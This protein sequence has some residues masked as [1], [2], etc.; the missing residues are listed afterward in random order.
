M[1]YTQH[2]ENMVR[3]VGGTDPMHALMFGA[4]IATDEVIAAGSVVSLDSDGDF[5]LGCTGYDM[6]MYAENGTTDLD[7]TQETGIFSGGNLAA[8]VGCAGVELFTSAYD[9]ASANSYARNTLLHAATGDDAGLLTEAA[10][11]AYNDA[12]ILGSVSRGLL[13]EGYQQTRLYF[14]SYFIP[15]VST[16]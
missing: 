14:F 8:Y 5:V 12:A 11:A 6:P 15:P 16:T 9:S 4:G 2:Y 3:I 10:S 7:V 1:S 13:T